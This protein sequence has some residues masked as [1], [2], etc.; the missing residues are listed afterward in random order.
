MSLLFTI[1]VTCYLVTT[2]AKTII[3]SSNVWPSL[4]QQPGIGYRYGNVQPLW[5]THVG[6]TK[7]RG[8]GAHKSKD[9]PAVYW[10]VGDDSSK[11]DKP[12]FKDSIPP[13]FNFLQKTKS[14]M[15]E[16]DERIPLYLDYESDF[17]D[18]QKSG[19]LGEINSLSTDQERRSGQHENQRKEDRKVDILRQIIEGRESRV[20]G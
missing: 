3:P 13:F 5:M 9:M 17:G 12:S 1:I 18:N 4:E 10:R 19:N 16:M 8:G 6:L 15:D 7:L 20:A 2:S 11:P 14:T